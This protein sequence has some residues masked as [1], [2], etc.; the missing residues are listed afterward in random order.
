MSHAAFEA[1]L[2]D[3]PDD[4]ATWCAFADWLAEQGDP[5]GAFMQTQLALEDE[6]RAKDERDALKAREAELLAEHQRE[7]LGPLTAFTLDGEPVRYYD[8]SGVG[9][10]PPVAHTF[11]R[12]WLHRVEL[13][14]AT[15]EQVRA[16]S[17]CPG[18]RLLQ[19]LIIPAAENERPVGQSERYIT[20]YY[21][22]GP[23]VPEDASAWEGPSLHALTHS[24]RLGGLRV[25]QLG[26][27]TPGLNGQKESTDN[28]HTS[29]Q[30]IPAL[31][32]QMPRLEELYVYAHRTD[33][34]ALFARSLPNL[35]VLLLYHG[36]SFPLD[37]LAAN[38]AFA[39]LEALLCH[40]HAMDYE[41]IDA[42]A[43]IRLEHLRAICRSPHLTKLTNLRLRLTDFGDKG[44]EEIVSS[45][46]LKRL[47]V[48]D[49]Q[50]GCITD[51]GAKAL[52]DCPDLKNLQFL[53]LNSNAIHGEGGLAL[54]GT[55]VRVSLDGQHDQTPGE[56]GD[57][58]DDVQIPEY[59]FE[60]DI[61]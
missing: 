22:P 9:T 53:N 27:G 20:S 4:L 31:V 29:G 19:E 61:E 43:Y 48:L 26:Y 13:H 35:R 60:G 11:R 32:A 36:R 30:L 58:G 21:E 17:V 34:D 33:T 39:N 52:A 55:G 2:H 28:C 16:L 38:P 24:P 23:D 14:R 57:R 5:R 51:A 37:R 45:G 50:G 40:P 10:R 8:G 42:G 15:V 6:S 56:F 1:A 49:L 18:A 3:N 25:F 54:I 47:K 46:I 59:L 7:W 41:D 44:V 12:G